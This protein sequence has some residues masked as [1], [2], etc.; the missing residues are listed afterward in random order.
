MK[1]PA[2][3]DDRARWVENILTDFY[4]PRPYNPAA[5]D[6]DLT[7]ALVATILSQHTSDLNSGRAYQSLRRAFPQGWDSVMNARPEVIADAIRSGGLADIKAVRI[8]NLLAEI[9]DRSGG[10]S[11]EHLREMDD[12]AAMAYLTGFHGVGP[13]T[14]ACVLMFN[15]GRGVIPVDTHVHRVALRLGLVPPKATPAATQDLLLARIGPESAYSF[16][17][18]LIEH[19]RA[20]CHAQRPACAQCPLTRCCDYYSHDGTKPARTAAK[21]R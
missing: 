2:E 10:L 15:L 16:H 12:Q 19:G 21:R 4:G 5:Y 17:V 7:G 9:E 8:R 3:T 14:A 18:H 6:S 13:K 1:S 20:I 11:L